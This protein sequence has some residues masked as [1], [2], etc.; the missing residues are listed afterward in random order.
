MAVSDGLKLQ[1]CSQACSVTRRLS[2]TFS[3]VGADGWFRTGDQGFLDQEGYLTLTGRIKELI[4]VAG[5]KVSPLE[6]GPLYSCAAPYAATWQD[7]P[8]Q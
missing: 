5:E 7:V 3:S 4:N 8:L 1:S 2:V 6:A